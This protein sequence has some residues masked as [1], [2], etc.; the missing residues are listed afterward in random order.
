MSTVECKGYFIPTDSEVELQMN[1][2]DDRARRRYF[3][4]HSHDTAMCYRYNDYDQIR[5][6]RNYVL[7]LK[8]IFHSKDQ[9][10]SV[11]NIRT[12]IDNSDLFSAS[13][14]T[15]QKLINAA[16]TC[17]TDENRDVIE[18]ALYSILRN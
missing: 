13:K 4:W 9:T 6:I 12:I 16:K 17:K 10:F 11:D 18:K 5:Y 8:R 1:S 14:E 2:Y 15:K 3:A 7:E